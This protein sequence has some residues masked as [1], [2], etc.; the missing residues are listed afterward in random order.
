VKPDNTQRDELLDRAENL[1]HHFGFL[2]RWIAQMRE[3]LIQLTL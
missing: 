1:Y 2:D 3:R